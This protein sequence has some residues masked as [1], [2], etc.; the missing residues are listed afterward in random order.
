MSKDFVIDR[1]DSKE[2]EHWNTSSGIFSWVFEVIAANVADPEIVAALNN[3]AT[4]GYGDF[5][6][7]YLSEEQAVEVVEAIKGPLLAAA[8]EEH[9][10]VRGQIQELVEMAVRWSTA[11][12]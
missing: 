12:P 4:M 7:S 11:R 1:K 8:Q 9:P 6:L 10:Y 3:S 2:F 5:A